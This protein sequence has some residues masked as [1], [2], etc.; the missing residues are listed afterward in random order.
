MGLADRISSIFG[1]SSRAIVIPP[2]YGLRD[3]LMALREA[4]RSG[5]LSFCLTVD[6][7]GR[8]YL[9]EMCPASRYL[10][11]E[12][13]ASLPTELPKIYQKHIWAQWG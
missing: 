6:K 1:V 7:K 5:I 12:D 13:L 3:T 4:E 11:I 2:M 9:G 8:D 10:V